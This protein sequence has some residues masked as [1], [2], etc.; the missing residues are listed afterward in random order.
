MTKGINKIEEQKAHL[1]EFIRRGRDEKLTPEEREVARMQAFELANSVL[2]EVTRGEKP[3]FI[4]N[5]S[6]KRFICSRSYASFWIKGAWQD[7]R[8]AVTAIHG[9]KSYRDAGYGGEPYQNAFGAGWKPKG[10]ADA[11]TAMQIAK[12]IVREI[13][14]D[15]PQVQTSFVSETNTQ[16]LRVFKT[17]GVF[18]SETEVPS[19]TDLKAAEDNLAYYDAAL[20]SEGN[21]IYEKTHDYKQIGALHHEAAARR[22]VNTA[23]HEN[24]LDRL[25]C[26]GCGGQVMK[27]AARCPNATCGWILNV[28]AVKNQARLRESI[29]GKP[30]PKAKN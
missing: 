24:Y 2:D 6:K 4:V 23:W 25:T 9:A 7:E 8:Y 30:A 27:S 29:E 17:L 13:N 11:Y 1:E 22:G 14:G 5:L 21:L 26:P 19:E 18:I 15:L 16:G 28:E 10:V 20:I 3:V 12:D